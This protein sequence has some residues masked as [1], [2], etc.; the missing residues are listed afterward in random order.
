M[1]SLKDH[2]TILKRYL[3][4]RAFLKIDT[5]EALFVSDAP[6]FIG[7]KLLYIPGYK[8]ERCGRILR[9]TPEFYDTPEKL[10]P[11]M[12]SMLKADKIRFNWL[13]RTNL[14]VAL[15]EHDTECAEFLKEFLNRE[16][17]YEA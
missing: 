5:A 1:L 3:P 2:R 12:P 16:E 6:R 17:D 8:T 7:D 13:I 11:I 9:I 10:R 4:E 15:R 14:A